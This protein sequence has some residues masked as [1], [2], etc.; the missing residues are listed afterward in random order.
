MAQRLRL[1]DVRLSRAPASVGLCQSDL[2]NI[3]Q[4]VDSAQRRLILAK[5]A[6]EEGWHGTFAEMVF[7]VQQTDPYITAPRDVARFEVMQMCEKP[8]YVQN[9]FYEYMRFGNGRMPKVF[10]GWTWEQCYRQA[11]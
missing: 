7:N 3:A 2:P 6:G 10:R 1:M 11:F 8:I 5:E 4:Y 9:Q